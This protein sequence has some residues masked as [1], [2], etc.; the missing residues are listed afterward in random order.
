MNPDNTKLLWLAVSFL[1]AVLAVLTSPAT[2]PLVQQSVQPIQQSVQQPPAPIEQPAPQEPTPQEVE[3]V[4]PP[5]SELD[6]ELQTIAETE[7]PAPELPEYTIPQRYRDMGLA[8]FSGT[9]Y[10]D[11]MKQRE[12]EK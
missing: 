11:R 7:E 9:L 6:N 8:R 4:E 5:P 1:C 12:G 2:P 10:R 3:A